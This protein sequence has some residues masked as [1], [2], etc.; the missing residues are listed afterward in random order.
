M[1][2]IKYIIFY[3]SNA[4]RQSLVQLKKKL[5]NLK[6]SDSTK[7]CLIRFSSFCTRTFKKY[8]FIKS[9]FKKKSNYYYENDTI[10]NDEDFIEGFIINKI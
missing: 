6:S 3:D 7:S 1:K 9:L 4:I 8:F 5:K 2:C 10:S